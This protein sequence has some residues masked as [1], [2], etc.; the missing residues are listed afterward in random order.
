MFFI[1]Y[2]TANIQRLGVILKRRK[3]VMQETHS[4]LYTSVEVLPSGPYIF[5]KSIGFLP[6]LT[7]EIVYLQKELTKMNGILT[8]LSLTSLNFF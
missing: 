6:N 3:E 1:I 2:T 8:C 7:K 4:L 5:P